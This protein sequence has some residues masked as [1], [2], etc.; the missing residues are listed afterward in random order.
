MTNNFSAGEEISKKAVE[1]KDAVVHTTEHTGDKLAKGARE[2]R[3][4]ISDGAGT[5]KSNR[6]PN[7]I[8]SFIF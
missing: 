8:N 1:V 6:D 4:S 5:G 3:T 2:A 7:R